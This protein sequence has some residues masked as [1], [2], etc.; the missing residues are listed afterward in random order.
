MEDIDM[1]DYNMPIINTCD[2][3][4]VKL[5]PPIDTIAEIEYEI[6][7][8]PVNFYSD[9]FYDLLEKYIDNIEE[10][11]LDIALDKND[12]EL[13]NQIRSYCQQKERYKSLK[14]ILLNGAEKLHS[15]AIHMLS[16][17]YRDIEFNI[18]EIKKYTFMYVS[19]T[20]EEDRHDFMS[21]VLDRYHEYSIET[22]REICEYITN[23]Y[24]ECPQYVKDDLYNNYIDDF[25]DDNEEDALIWDNFVRQYIAHL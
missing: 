24:N 17:Y 15:E 5:K 3:I 6:I 2:F 25:I 11:V 10:N 8:I 20:D 23:I 16:L 13:Y 19:Q 4:I 21:V 12:C 14:N 18:E 9:E 7:N 1:T 22:K